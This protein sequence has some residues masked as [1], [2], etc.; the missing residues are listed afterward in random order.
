MSDLTIDAATI[1]EYQSCRRRFVL[2][3]DYRPIKW[4]P[5]SLFDAC[6]RAGIQMLSTGADAASVAT[7]ATSRFMQTAA[8][9]GMDMRGNPYIVAKDYCAML[10]T[11]LRAIERTRPAKMSE[12][13]PTRFN[14][15]V[16]WRFLSH[17]DDTGTLHRWVTVSSWGEDDIA[18]ELHGWHVFG[19]MVMA[20]AP[21]VLHV[22]E[23][24]QI[25]T[26][27]GIARRASLWA[28]AWRHPTM[29]SL[30]IRF[31]RNDGEGFQGWQ[32]YYLAD[33]ADADPAE[34]VDA[35][36]KENAAQPLMHDINVRLP[37]AEVI[38][39]TQRQILWEATGMREMARDRGSS[40]WM[41]LPMSRASCDGMI[42]CPFQAA[43]YQSEPIDIETLNL[44]Q[45]RELSIV[46]TK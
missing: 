37:G 42:P 2:S 45:S 38:E 31:R 29:A 46:G 19:D 17:A 7:D 43:C 22:I 33:H 26:G 28:R 15:Q 44:F 8:N 20:R 24:G 16:S 11:V 35:M 39:D 27:R 41:A 32:P 5:K 9:P 13:P 40:T 30:R 10:E 23:I 3:H 21:M 25:R 36:W 4:R 6:L 12:L 18:R 34:W 14:S 1:A